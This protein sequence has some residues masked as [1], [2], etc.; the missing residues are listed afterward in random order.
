MRVRGAL[1]RRRG[2]RSACIR[3]RRTSAPD[4]RAGAERCCATPSTQPARVRGRRDR[5][6]L[7]LR[8]LAARR[9]ADGL[10]R[11]ARHGAL[12][13]RCPSSST[14]ARRTTTRSRSSRSEGR[15]VRRR[16][17]LLH[18]RR[19]AG[20]ARARPGLLPVVCRHPDVPEG[21][22]T[23]A[24]PRR[25]VPTTGCSSRPTARSSRPCRIAAS[26]TSRRGSRRVVENAGGDSRL[27][28]QAIARRR[29][30]RISL[31]CS[32]EDISRRR[33]DTLARSC[34]QID[35]L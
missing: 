33:V 23:C 9:A 16:V 31:R 14:R 24:R 34:G 17:P 13:R 22:P 28:P 26:G 19:R 6:R 29:P 11:A 4:S 27:G 3:T 18:G 25:I 21:A 2:S 5:A 35:E 1:G 30:R 7:P 8:L 20:A 12:A 32:A 10:R 15:G